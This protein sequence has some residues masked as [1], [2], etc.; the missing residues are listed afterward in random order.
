MRCLTQR[1][2]LVITGKLWRGILDYRGYS[3]YEFKSNKNPIGACLEAWIQ[4]KI[5]NDPIGDLCKILTTMKRID[6]RDMLLKA[7]GMQVQSVAV[8][9][10]PAPTPIPI[11]RSIYEAPPV[12]NNN[13]VLPSAPVKSEV[14]TRRELSPPQSILLC[15]LLNENN[16]WE[17]FAKQL[18]INDE[19]CLLL[20]ARSRNPCESAIDMWMSK[21]APDNPLQDIVN[22]LC[23]IGKSDIADMIL[24]K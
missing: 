9:P 12:N 20:C 7:T 5:T 2:L 6:V 4:S 15:A 3:Q 18:G 24:S 21:F 22:A 19:M 17:R 13:V 8:A 11:D 10:T 14:V 23:D 1:V 16:E